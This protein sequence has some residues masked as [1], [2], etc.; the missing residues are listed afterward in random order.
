MWQSGKPFEIT[1]G[2]HRLEAVGYGP[3]PDSADTIVLLHEG[4]GSVALWKDFPRRLA[5][6][7]G[8][9]VLAY[10]RACYGKSEVCALPRGVDYMHREA[11][12]VLPDVLKAVGF[13]RGILMGHSDGASIAAI[14]AGGVQDHRVRGLVLMAPHFFVEP[15]TKT[16][17]L[18]ARKTFE[19][20]DLRQRLGLYHAN[21]DAAF[22]GWNDAW[23]NPAFQDWDISE[24]LAF[25]RV[26]VLGIQGQND[27]Y[28][29][30]AQVDVLPEQL[31]SPADVS[32]LTGIGHSPHNEDPD[33]VLSL[34]GAFAGQL[35]RI[36]AEEV[37]IASA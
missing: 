28:G 26:P 13:E 34:V 4:L 16:S 9:G 8:T 22:R 25:I 37:E 32:L 6:T 33:K 15:C 2:G 18:A 36:E 14:Y 29:T 27:P 35:A 20:G 23:I 17:A 7:T 3:A 30:R 19:N 21:V 5:E 12:D 10:S 11:L 1:A 24:F 31:Y